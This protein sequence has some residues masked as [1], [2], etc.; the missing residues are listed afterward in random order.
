MTDTSSI[1]D[2]TSENHTK[3]S[4][5]VPEAPESWHKK[6]WSSVKN[7]KVARYLSIGLFLLVSILAVATLRPQL[8]VSRVVAAPPI[9][10]PQLD[11]D[12]LVTSVENINPHF[13]IKHIML[14]NGTKLIQDVIKGPPKNPKGLADEQASVVQINMATAAAVLTEVPAFRWVLGCSA[15]S[16]AMIAGYYDRMGYP[17]MYTGPTNGGMI[18]LK[19]DLSWGYWSFPVGSNSYPN[20]PLI[21]SNLGLDGRTILGTIDDYWIQYTS[22]APDP[23]ITGGWTQHT[24]GDAIGDYMKTSQSYYGNTD[25]STYFYWYGNST[26]LTCSAMQS[27]GYSQR[28]GTFGRKLFYEARGYTV[29]DCYY[30]PTDNVYAGGFSLANFKAEIDAGRPVFLS[31]TGH[32]IVGVGYDP[33]ST[34]IYIHDTW[35]NSTH[36][37]LWG[38]IYGTMTMRGASI[39]NLAGTVN[40][41]PTPTGFT[42]TPTR[43]PTFTPTPTPKQGDANGD[44][45]VDET[46]Y[47]IWLAHFGQTGTG[48]VAIGDFN[49][50]SKVDGIDFS[51]W[52]L[53]YGR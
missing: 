21:A 46:D 38:G 10:V 16:G 43:T 20:N 48:G 25:G 34:T 6:V 29:S 35:D 1:T 23:Y 32:S 17:N 53:H 4:L 13:T 30:Q 49:G 12:K 42:P 39:V 19:E 47:G 11:T 31:L 18:P 3:D 51:I 22:S 52:T 15:V 5:I 44:M 14:P 33:A 26:K 50:D 27:G 28:D 8:A 36:E 41:T 7:P 45:K 9:D 24:W 40:P 2:F 37:M